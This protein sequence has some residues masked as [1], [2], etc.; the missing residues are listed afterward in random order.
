[1]YRY[2][3]RGRDCRNNL[4][5]LPTGEII[6]FIA[7]VV[8]LHNVEENTQR[9]YTGHTDDVKWWETC[10]SSNIWL[11]FFSLSQSSLKSKF[12]DQSA[13]HLLGFYLAWDRRSQCEKVCN[14]P[15]QRLM[16]FSRCSG[17]LHHSWTIYLHIYWNEIIL[18]G[19]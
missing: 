8:I 5:Y 9:H 19:A 18:I 15:C 3:Y 7:G 14:F 1:M 16:V 6:Y 13:S 11:R 17:S 2:G 4:Y 10:N 12:M